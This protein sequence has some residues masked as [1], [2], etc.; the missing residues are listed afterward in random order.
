MTRSWLLA[1][2]AIAACGDDTGPP[3]ARR[4]DGPPAAGTISLSWTIDDDGT[5]LTCSQ[6]GASVVSLTII[7]VDQPFGTTDAI[8]C[9]AGMGTSRPLPP[10]E[11]HVTAALGGITAEAVE[12]R[13]VVIDPGAD[14]PLGTAAFQVD[15]VG[16]FQFQIVAGGQG[17][18]TP[19]AQGGAGIEAME[20]G[21]E[22]IG[23]TC[24]PVTFDIAA[25]ATQPAGTFSSTCPP[26]GQAPCIAQDQ[27]VSVAPTVPSGSYR[28][29]IVGR[30]GGE[31]CWAR[32][33]QFEVPAGAVVRSLP[34]QN[35]IHAD[36]IPACNP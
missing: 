4:F 33:S 13:D 31:P 34:Q 17:N 22:T 2:V 28:L 23:G 16:G 32:T 36:G 24:V 29:T 3:D 8:S 15:A 21:L 19:P 9:S 11:Y 26:A 10:G 18:C 6:I 27:D 30:I 35:L 1:I 14:T 20:L 12:F 25:G 7:P 5:P